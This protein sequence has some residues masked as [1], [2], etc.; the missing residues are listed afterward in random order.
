[1]K[2]NPAAA[3][4]LAFGLAASLCLGCGTGIYDGRGEIEVT[5]AIDKDADTEVLLGQAKLTILAG[6]LT[7]STVLQ[8]RRIP[9]ISQ[10]GAIG[11]VFEVSVPQ[12]GLLTQVATLRIWVP[13]IGANQPKLVFGALETIAAA[14]GQNWVPSTATKRDTPVT[15]V[16]GP[17]TP[18][19]FAKRETWRFAAVVEC[20]AECPEGQYCSSNACQRCPN[21]SCP[22]RE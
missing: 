4:Q 18:D 13:D 16:E 19:Y 2:R 22:P 7:E 21:D 11:P 8:M 1:M 3:A 15:Y 14:P 17:L 5:A 10:W 20:P 12:R 9:S 6:N